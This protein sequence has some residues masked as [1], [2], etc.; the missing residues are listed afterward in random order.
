MLGATC[1]LPLMRGMAYGLWK[2]LP[3]SLPMG[4]DGVCVGLS[5]CVWSKPTLPLPAPPTMLPVWSASMQGMAYSLW[6]ELPQPSPGGKRMGGCL[7]EAFVCRA[8]PPYHFLLCQLCCLY[9][10]R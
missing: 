4:R 2:E 5:L 1:G 10:G 7:A 9:V 3:P 8:S 6:K